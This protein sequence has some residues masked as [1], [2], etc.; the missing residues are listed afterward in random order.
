MGQRAGKAGQK[1]HDAWEGKAGG[2]EKS[3]RQQGGKA[4]ISVQEGG[5]PGA[6]FRFPRLHSSRFGV[7]VLHPTSGC[8]VTYA[9]QE[10]RPPSLRVIDVTNIA[11]SRRLGAP[12]AWHGL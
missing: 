12:V 4:A 8:A 1:Q 3:K 10:C 11:G 9:Y 6:S 5:G 2:Q 7:A